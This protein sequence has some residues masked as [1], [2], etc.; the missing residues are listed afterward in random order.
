[1]PRA[2]SGGLF[3]IETSSERVRK[4]VQGQGMVKEVAQNA[5][6]VSLRS[7][8]PLGAGREKVFPNASRQHSDV[9]KILVMLTGLP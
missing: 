9:V 4:R 3:L 2:S 6:A 5:D 1:M 8:V 7:Q